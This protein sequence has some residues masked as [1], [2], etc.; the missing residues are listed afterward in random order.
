VTDS[1]GFVSPVKSVNTRYSNDSSGAE[2][3][4]GTGSVGNA[5]A[6]TGAD[7]EKGYN[8]LMTRVRAFR[9]M[10]PSDVVVI[11]RLA[12]GLGFELDDDA[13]DAR[14]RAAEAKALYRRTVANN[15][16]KVADKAKEAKACVEA[17][18]KPE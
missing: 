17:T 3:N 6:H 13:L 5:G 7:A 8:D 12:L 11:D 14:Q 18:V 4:A 9:P 16:A 15:K 10:Q 1:N 2:A